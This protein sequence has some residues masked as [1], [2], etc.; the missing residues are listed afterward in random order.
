MIAAFIPL[1]DM[2]ID[3]DK[4]IDLLSL[5]E[6]EAIK[7][8][9][10]SFGFL[11]SSIEVSIKN[12]IATIALLEEEEAKTAEAPKWY[13]H[14]VTNAEQGNYK[15]AIQQFK[16][17]LEVLPNHIDA[18]RN[19]AMAYLE[20]GDKETA[21]NLLIQVLKLDPKDEWSYVLLGNIALKHEND[22][23]RAEKWYRK[24]FEL[25]PKDAI[26]LTNY[27]A[28]MT[29][30]GD[31][32]QA[33]EFMERAIEADPA[34]PNSYHALAVLSTREHKPEQALQLLDDMFSKAKSSDIRSGTVYNEARKMYLE[35]NRQIADESYDR[36]MQAID[37]RKQALE[38]QEGGLPI[39][40]VED[41]SLEVS[42]VSQMAWRHGRSKHTIKYRYKAR[43]VTPHL[44]AHA[45][46]QIALEY[47]ARKV[48]RNRSFATTEETKQRA[49]KSI[50]SD[51]FRLRDLGLPPKEITEYGL[52]LV[53]GLTL[54]LYNAPFD[55]VIEYRLFHD[56]EVMR[57]SQFASLDLLQAEA[58]AA[59]TNPEIKRQSPRRIWKANVTLSCAL[60]LVVDSLYKGKTDYA[61]PY[62]SLDVFETGQELFALWQDR[63]R[64]LKS[65]DEYT[66]VDEFARV[67]KLEEWFVWQP[68]DA[69]AMADIARLLS[70]RDKP[71]PQG[72]TNPEL[73]KSKEPATIM[74]LLGT[75]E[76]FEK[77]TEEQIK[78]IGLEI[79]IRGMDG[80]DY[81]SSD[82]KYT[83]KAFPGETFSGLQML[84]FMYV[85]FKHIDPTVSTGL[86]FKDAY[87]TAV[88][89]YDSKSDDGG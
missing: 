26:L 8:I 31:R 43:A 74:Y 75:L 16:K 13:Q 17:V 81:A 83:L 86:D 82:K 41:E 69:P 22:L 49:I 65:G 66:L 10:E 61:R 85:A 89:M 46:E 27:G 47:A 7:L 70:E 73:L 55:M 60:A 36:L 72:T 4:D 29:E 58:V 15:R 84:C 54:Q 24:A 32:E 87:D 33:A 34:Y 39:E 19:L 48:G 45:L 51:L 42:T 78:Q 79:G 12:G 63:M 5:P 2:V 25:N 76:R 52:K 53:E 71:G 80:I 35:V 40:I 68:D 59:V 44:V 20:S 23:V 14:G 56:F 88:K 64:D 38:K 1:K 50:D 77:L 28:L 62:R 21:K 3:P 11:S 67:L 6:A 18:R 57:Q 9:K 30:K 37:E